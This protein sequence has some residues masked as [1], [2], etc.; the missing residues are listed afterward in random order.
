[1]LRALPKQPGMPGVE[2]LHGGCWGSVSPSS[3]CYGVAAVVLALLQLSIGARDNCANVLVLF[4]TAMGTAAG[5]AGQ[6][7]RAVLILL[8][9]QWQDRPASDTPSPSLHSARTACMHCRPGRVAKGS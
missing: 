4:D 2:L 7:G 9:Q 3:L 8:Q 1:M 6:E 5:G